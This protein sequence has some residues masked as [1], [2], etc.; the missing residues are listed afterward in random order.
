MGLIYAEVELFN[1]DDLTRAHDNV[2]S[3]D[4]V[5]SLK[6]EKILVDTGAVMLTINEP[7]QA[8]LQCRVL[9]RHI[10]ELADG[11]QQECDIVGPVELRFKNRLTVCRA[12]VLPSDCEPLLGAIPLEDMDVLIDPLRQELIVHPLRPNMARIKIPSIRLVPLPADTTG[13]SVL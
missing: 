12:I 8:H 5:R 13:P 3:K 2:I 1:A 6:V 11:E 7:M 4:D 9:G 10:V